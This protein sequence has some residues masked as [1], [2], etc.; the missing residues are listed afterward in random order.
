MTDAVHTVTVEPATPSAGIVMPSNEAMSAKLQEL[1]HGR[2]EIEDPEQPAEDDDA[3]KTDEESPPSD[4]PKEGDEK[5][6]EEKLGRVAKAKAKI[7]AQFQAKLEAAK[8]RNEDLEERDTQWKIAANYAV[9]QAKSWQERA[10]SAE[11]RLSELG[12]PTD[13]R[14]DEIVSLRQQMRAR[15][16]EQTARA[17]QS[18]ATQE[19]TMRDGITSQV[20]SLKDQY[21]EEADGLAEKY[22]VSRT[23][24]LRKHVLLAESG[25]TMDEAAQAVREAQSRRSAQR[26]AA[27]NATAPRVS[28]RSTGSTPHV[29]WSTSN[30]DMI[31]FLKSRGHAVD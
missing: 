28:A 17:E 5:K 25:F 13:P 22:G 1:G 29:R 14:D 10:R 15:E 26:Q 2:A 18:R 27:T 7:T 31:G 19:R 30:K 23:D 24:I 9:E 11:A 8:K 12:H 3:P 21:I 16:L 4:E 6:P 20:E